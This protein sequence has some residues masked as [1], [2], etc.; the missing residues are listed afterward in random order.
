MFTHRHGH[1]SY[2]TGLSAW[3]EMDVGFVVA[4]PAFCVPQASNSSLFLVLREG[5]G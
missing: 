3:G 4:V 5:E 2:F 1:T